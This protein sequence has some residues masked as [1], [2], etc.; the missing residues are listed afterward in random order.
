MKRAILNLGNGTLKQGCDTV[1][2]ELLE[3]DHRS[4]SQRTASLP[5][6]PH[7][8]TLYQHWQHLYLTR[9]ENQLFRIQVSRSTGLRYS[10]ADFQ[11]TCSALSRKLNEWLHAAQFRSIDQELRTAFSRDEAFQVIVATNDP[12][13]HRLPWHLWQFFEDYPNAEIALSRLDWQTLPPLQPATDACRILALLG[14]TREIDVEVDRAILNDLPGADLTVLQN[15]N[16]RQFN[17]Y[18]WDA[19]GWDILF[20]AGHSQTVGNAGLIHFNETESLTIAQFKHALGKAMTN[21][22]KLAIFNSCDGIGLAHQLADLQIPYTIVM[23]EPV[24][25]PVAQTFLKFFFQAFSTGLPFHQAV[26]EARQ[27]LETLESEIP[28]A[29]WLPVIWQNPTATP[30]QCLDRTP[31]AKILL[32]Q[33]KQRS[34][35]QRVA[36]VGAIVT[37][38]VIGVRSLGVLEPVEL[39]AYDYLVRQRPTEPIDPRILVI[40]VTEADTNRYGYPLPDAILVQLMQ[41][42]EKSQARAIGLDMHRS[43][44]RG[45]SQSALSQLF[46]Q[47]QR[48]FMVCSFSSQDKS[49]APPPVSSPE[50]LT[51]QMGFSDLLVDGSNPVKRGNRSD[52]VVG[53]QPLS[54]NLTV[55]RQLLSYDPSLQPVPSNCISPYGLGFQLAFQFLDVEN[56]QPLEVNA[57]Q[58]WQFGPITFSDLPT[59]F[60]GYQKLDGN[61][62]QIV[63]HYR[64]NQPGRRASLSQ[65]LSGQVDPRWI[66]NQVVLVGYT[67]PIAR[68]F[69]ET[70]Y[71]SMAGVWIHAHMVSQKLSA[72]LDRRSLIWTLPQWRSFQWGDMVCI[73]SGSIAGGLIVWGLWLKPRR[74]SGLALAL[75]TWVLYQLC[76]FALIHGCWLPWVPS[77]LS[78][79][80]SSGFLLIHHA[81]RRK[82]TEKDA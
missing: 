15:S 1:F 70:P 43:Q 38:L 29:S 33:P 54:G 25:D 68:D 73:F 11:A 56:I 9:N 46:E 10:D 34:G 21:G 49:H 50:K 4:P 37:A 3:L 47:S 82:E 13:L 59:R 27:K 69:F 61:S 12:A 55:R 81:M 26:R 51:Q 60:G 58:E 39:A 63:I 52:V 57:E 32:T 22:L 16:P 44:S 35:L 75:A 8:E 23:R 80:S 65:V 20:F 19:R 30:F 78:F 71:G 72:V 24:P 6:A 40:E 28:C 74:Y 79:L 76:L 18:L 62:S 2:L 36:A 42:L 48:L 41:K 7:L 67:A 53:E 5:P 31:P 17:E 66:Q 64:A 14:D 45:N 77:T